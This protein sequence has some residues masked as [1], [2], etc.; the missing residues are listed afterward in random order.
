MNKKTLTPGLAILTLP[1]LLSGCSGKTE[2]VRISLCR[3]LSTTLLSLQQPPQW[4]D[5]KTYI[6]R[7]AYAQITLDFKAESSM[8]KTINFKSVCYYQHAVYEENVITHTDPLSAYATLPYKMT[9]NGRNIPKRVINDATNAVVRKQGKEML[10]K[11]RKG[12]REA[13]GMIK[14]GIDGWR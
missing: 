1:L 11:A 4:L 9:L 5:Q 12:F 10:E 7:P 3:N 13:M 2:D 14:E 6:K 8:G